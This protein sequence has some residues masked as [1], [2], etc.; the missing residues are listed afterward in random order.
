MWL[1]CV[2]S[3]RKDIEAEMRKWSAFDVME[4]KIA[5]DNTNMVINAYMRGL[6][7]AVGSERAVE[8]ALGFLEPE[9]LKDQICLRTDRA[10]DAIRYLGSEEMR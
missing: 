10:L 6:Y 3:H 1:S 7:G 2:V 4:G 8:T 5:N 9:R